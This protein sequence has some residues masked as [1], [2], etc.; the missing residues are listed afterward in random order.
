MEYGILI[1]KEFRELFEK[2]NS[3]SYCSVCQEHKDRKKFIIKDKKYIKK[4]NT[5]FSN[6]LPGFSSEKISKSVDLLIVADSHSGTPEKLFREQIG[7]EKEVNDMNE[8]YRNA[9]METFHQQE[10][11]ELL[12]KLDNKKITWVFTDLIKC[13]VWHGNDKENIELNGYKNRNTAITH[14]KKYLD[15]QIKVLNPKIILS[16]GNTVSEGYFKLKKLE[17]AKKYIEKVKGKDYEIIHSVFPSR[18]T[19]DLWVKN[20]GWAKILKQLENNNL[21][22]KK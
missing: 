8:Y 3:K 11:R 14:C 5:N 18:N 19:A 1:N 10:I 15:E 13:Y 22:I 6:V 17:H 9:E 7:L 16:L 21:K 2:I 12:K 20:K 4:D